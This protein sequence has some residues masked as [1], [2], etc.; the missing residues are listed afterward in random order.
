MKRNKSNKTNDIIKHFIGLFYFN[1]RKSAP[2]CVSD[3]SP[4]RTQSI[5][6]EINKKT[7]CASVSP[8]VNPLMSWRDF[9]WGNAVTSL[10]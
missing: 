8:V 7:L 3:Y 9:V 5:T 4:Q 10:R 2:I 1:L 6:E